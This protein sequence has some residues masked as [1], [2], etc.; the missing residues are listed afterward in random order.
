MP[1]ALRAVLA[2][3]H[4]TCSLNR[5][6]EDSLALLYPQPV[7]PNLPTFIRQNIPLAP[8]TTLRVG[9]SARY[10]ATVTTLAELLEALAFARAE[11][12]PL[13]TL[14]GGS[15]LLV[16]DAGFPGLVLHARFSSLPATGN[17]NSSSSFTT[18]VAAGTEW[19]AFVL[20]LCER[21]LSGVECLAGIPGLVGGAPIQN[22]GAY[23]QEVAQTIDSVTAL[24]LET[25]AVTSLS[26]ADCRFAYRSSIFNTTHRNRYIILGVT[27]RFD[28]D[29]HPI[30][31]YPDLQ[32]HFMDQP[33]PTPLEIYHAVRAIRRAKGMLI[34]EDDSNTRSAGSF[35]KNPIVP[36]STLTAIAQALGLDEATIP[37]WPAGSE[38]GQGTVKLPAAWLLEHAGFHKGFA[39][40][41]AGISSQHTLA[42]IN[43]TGTATY[44]DIANL[45]DTILREILHRF[46]VVLEQEPVQLGEL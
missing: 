19:N 2:S 20:S 35:F 1:E 31:T 42:L 41:A 25:L 8:C 24:D 9:G 11:N 6:L 39:L 16:T 28:P 43:R 26:H 15:N 22:I 5:R 30:L 18:S 40:G 12:L 21:G 46:Q 29:A 38:K 23:G 4:P 27:F 14:G 32:R 17:A 44:A 7:R 36:A 33:T 37:H 10:F 3:A 13:F 34:V 45:R